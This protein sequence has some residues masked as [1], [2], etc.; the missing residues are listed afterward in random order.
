MKRYGAVLRIVLVLV[1]SLCLCPVVSPGAAA[2]RE[3]RPAAKRGAQ[4]T[5]AEESPVFTA[6]TL[7]P[8]TREEL[9]GLRRASD[10]YAKEK[11]AEAIAILTPLAESGSARAAFSLGLMAVRG[12]GMPMSTEVAEYWWFRSAKGGFPDAQ[13][14]LGIM[15]HQALRGPRNPEFIAQLWK[16]AAASGQGDA[17]FGL[18]FMYRAGDGV[19]KDPQKSLAMFTEAARMGHPG[20][21]YELGLMYTYGRGGVQKDAAR[22]KQYL[23][24][25]ARAGMS[26]AQ[27]DPA[28]K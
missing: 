10:A 24:Q 4:T 16:L 28:G 6:D 15:H 14:H 3:A 22:G 7:A 13:Y 23:D 18:G 1:V 2:A 21:A 11:Y 26:Q 19:E 8:A 17:M 9:A 20:A 12:K 27:R 25:A 5:R